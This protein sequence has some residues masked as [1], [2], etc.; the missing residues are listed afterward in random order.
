MQQKKK[1]K[2]L[3]IDSHNKKMVNILT[4]NINHCMTLTNF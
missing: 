1:K 3:F 4:E 2:N